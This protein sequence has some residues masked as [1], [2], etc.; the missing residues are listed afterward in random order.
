MRKNKTRRER[1]LIRFFFF[2][3]GEFS[4]RCRPQKRKTEHPSP[5]RCTPFLTKKKK[6]CGQKKKENERD[7]KR[8]DD[9]ECDDYEKYTFAPPPPI[10]IINDAQ[11]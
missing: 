9:D 5:P 6:L 7:L 4:R 2:L 11:Y 3:R 8:D 10:D 1:E